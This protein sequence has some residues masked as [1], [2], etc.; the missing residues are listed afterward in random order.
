M[1]L[2]NEAVRS[3]RLF[4]TLGYVLAGVGILIVVAAIPLAIF[5]DRRKKARRRAAQAKNRLPGDNDNEEN[6]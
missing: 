3:A 5:L 2:D 4:E 1:P 6:E